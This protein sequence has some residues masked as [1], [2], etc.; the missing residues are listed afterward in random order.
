MCR[1][2]K[3]A[4]RA[5]AKRSPEQPGRRRSRRGAP[6]L[7]GYFGLRGM[8]IEQQ[9]LAHN[10]HIVRRVDCESHLVAANGGDGDADIVIEDEGLARPAGKFQHG[11]N[12]LQS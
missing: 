4:R 7:S 10:V 12:P 8:G 9:L 1:G 3:R 5:G 11:R 2:A 6:V